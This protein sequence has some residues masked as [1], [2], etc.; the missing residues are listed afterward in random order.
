VLLRLDFS[1]SEMMLLM[2]KRHK[3]SITNAKSQAN[4]KLFGIRDSQKVKE[5][6]FPYF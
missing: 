4:E 2:G 6:L 3:Q 1:E 5:N